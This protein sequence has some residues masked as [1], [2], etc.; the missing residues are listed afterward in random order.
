MDMQI[1]AKTIGAY[2]LLRH[3]QQQAVPLYIGRSDTCLRRRLA[4]H[5]LRG[6][7]TH[8]VA[9][10][11]RNHHQAFAIESAW[12]HRY[13]AAGT[14]IANQIHPASPAGTGRRCPFCPETE[15]ERAL[16]RAFPSP[17]TS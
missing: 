13:R 5:P 1:P 6:H 12:Y 9:A 2:V 11:T 8:F 17:R 7:A 3:D 10:P 4:Y 15:I 16:R 14:P